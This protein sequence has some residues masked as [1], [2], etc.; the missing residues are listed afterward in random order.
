MIT[1]WFLSAP[2][3]RC[4]DLS[5]CRSQ[6]VDAV[7]YV[8]MSHQRRPDEANHANGGPNKHQRHAVMRELWLHGEM[9]EQMTGSV[10]THSPWHCT[11]RRCRCSDDEIMS[12]WRSGGANDG[13]TVHLQSLA[14]YSWSVPCPNWPYW[15]LPALYSFPS[16]SHIVNSAPHATLVHSDTN[17]L[18]GVCSS[19][20]P[21]RH[22]NSQAIPIWL[23]QILGP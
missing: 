2:T 11:H 19:S 6:D 15:G 23:S 9:S 10:C 17:A 20:E 3:L 7:P 14:L 8:S 1:I 13:E 5:P 18:T 4:L 21:H 22:T 16:H 12:T